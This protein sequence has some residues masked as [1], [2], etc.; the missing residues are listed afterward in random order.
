[1]RRRVAQKRNSTQFTTIARPGRTPRRLTTPRAE[2][3]D[4]R[5]SFNT[6]ARRPRLSRRRRDATTANVREKDIYCAH[7]IDIV[8]RAPIGRPARGT[9]RRRS[10][11][12][13]ERLRLRLT[14]T[15]RLVLRRR[16][17]VVDV[18]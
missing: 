7:P 3:H 18:R 5:M 6:P 12:L 4:M 17:H 8:P 16:V 11:H 13:H 15:Q 14:A 10:R 1:V 2:S 9:A